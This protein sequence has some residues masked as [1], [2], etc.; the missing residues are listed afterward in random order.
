MSPALEPN[1]LTT[2]PTSRIPSRAGTRVPTPQSLPFLIRGKE[3]SIPVFPTLE[4]D[5][6]TL[7]H[8]GGKKT[9]KRKRKRR[10]EKE[11]V[12][13]RGREEEQQQEDDC[14]SHLDDSDSPVKSQVKATQ[15]GD[16]CQHTR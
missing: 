5:A 7:G 2:R 12:E 14:S 6:S 16:R 4:V 15:V 3:D 10:R 9:M 1:A 8:G 13:G 11:E